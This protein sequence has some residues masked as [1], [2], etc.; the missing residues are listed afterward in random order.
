MGDEGGNVDLPASQETH[1]LDRVPHRRVGGEDRETLAENRK[2]VERNPACARRHAEEQDP[3]PLRANAR[4]FSIT[5]GT[6][7]ASTTTS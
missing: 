5:A 7:V 1:R 6:P 4:V 2:R 3:A